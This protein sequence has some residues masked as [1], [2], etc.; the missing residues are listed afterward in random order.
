MKNRKVH[1]NRDDMMPQLRYRGKYVYGWSIIRKDNT[2]HFP[3]D[4]INE[5][6][7]KKNSDIILFSGSKISGGFCISKSDTLKSSKL[8][9]IIKDNPEL[10]NKE[11]IGQILKYKGKIYCH[12]KLT[13][14]NEIT[15]TGEIINHFNVKK[16]DK[17]LI[18][19]GSDIAFDCIIKGPLID[20]ANESSKNIDI[21]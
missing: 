13:G 8:S 20:V 5:Y 15:L 17:L 10:E 3:P 21:F 16:E 1:E 6:G 14:E 4:V 19:K 12:L 7:L 18:I 11:N 9:R 2:I